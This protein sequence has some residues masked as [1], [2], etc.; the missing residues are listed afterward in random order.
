MLTLLPGKGLG[1]FATRDVSRGELLL[2][3]EPLAVVY[4]PQG[5][6]PSNSQLEQQLRSPQ[7]TYDQQAWLQLLY[8]SDLAPTPY[9]TAQGRSRNSTSSGTPSVLQ[10]LPHERLSGV[11]QLLHGDV[12]VMEEAARQAQQRLLQESHPV[13]SS[14]SSATPD[15]A[16]TSNPGLSYSFD[17]SDRQ[18]EQQPTASPNPEPLLSNISARHLFSPLPTPPIASAQDRSSSSHYNSLPPHPVFDAATL[19]ALVSANCYGEASEDVAVA[20][21]RDIQPESYLGMWPEFALA[22]HSCAA[23]TSHVVVGGRL[24]LHASRPILEGQEVTTCYL[25]T[26]RLLHVAERRDTLRARYGFL[27]GCAR[28]TLEQEIFPTRR[29]RTSSGSSGATASFP[30]EAANNDGGVQRSFSG[31]G[32]HLEG[33]YKTIEE[34][35]ALREEERRGMFQA[36]LDWVFGK[37]RFTT[38]AAR[39]NLMLLH[40]NEAVEGEL[41]GAMQVRLRICLIHGQ[42]VIQLS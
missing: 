1:L 27:C 10:L 17:P 23:N 18:A 3:S 19:Q 22:N 13:H 38:N 26:Q 35:P 6:V 20:E 11:L 9:P 37:G 4:G 41:R 31:G 7:L 39:D 29:Y 2:V 15:C 28:C 40:V 5:D 32:S 42:W 34:M 25:G 14:S 24:L 16:S 21:L 36:S 30:A 12:G 33:A 8:S